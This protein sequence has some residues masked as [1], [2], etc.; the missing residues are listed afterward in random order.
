MCGILE[1]T[2]YSCLTKRSSATDNI[3]E[4]KE[5]IY[6]ECTLYFEL[7]FVLYRCSAIAAFLFKKN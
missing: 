3:Y 2:A 1:I 7:V 6:V 5:I 4:I